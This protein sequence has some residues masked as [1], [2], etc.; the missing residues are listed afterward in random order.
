MG[1]ELVLAVDIGTSSTKALLFDEDLNQKA[2]CR[3]PNR[4][5][6]RAGGRSEQDPDDVFV[7]VLEAMAEALRATQAR[8][9]LA[10][11]VI[12]SQMYSVLALSAD[13]RPLTN[14]I[15]WL[16]HRAA[17]VA[18]NFRDH[19][20]ASQLSERTGC[21]I[22]PIF[23]FS[24]ILW[25][26]E[27]GQIPADA[28]FIS[29]KEY[30]LY[31]L[32][33]RLLADWAIGSSSGLMDIRTREWDPA[34]V[35][36]TRLEPSNLPVLTTPSTIITDWDPMVAEKVGVPVGTP[37]ILGSGDGPL[38]SVGVGALSPEILAINVGTSA[39]ARCVINMPA[40]DPRGRL[41][42]QAFDETHW[43][44]GGMTSSGGI[45]HEWFLEQFCSSIGPDGLPEVK[46]ADR[47]AAERLA[48]SVPP[49]SDGLMFIPYLSGEQSPGWQAS[50]RGSFI[51][52]TLK[53]T[54]GH[55]ARSVLEGI[56]R[57]LYRIGEAFKA[58]PEFRG[59]S[60]REIRVT[61]GLTASPLGLQIM[62][63]MFNLPVIVP[64][65][66]EGSARGAAILAWS[67]L[68]R[69]G[70]TKDY[71]RP[72]PVKARAEPNADAHFCYQQQLYEHNLDLIRDA[73]F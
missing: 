64:E 1:N 46:S 49:G 51:G 17:E 25:L 21:P 56:T 42:T 48:A 34:A 63:D 14:S 18:L 20:L 32:T 52:L 47:E 15:T 41:Y 8:D 3:R 4:I 12:S 53:H 39:A 67:T 29:I 54:R 37:I 16:D 71:S 5:L 28:R 38:A 72:L 6:D 60:F 27:S 62:A 70:T 40:G 30:V 13:G 7:G 58:V 23:P 33:G 9:R 55:L 69:S 31:R 45:V 10:A 26:K 2:S 43:V 68:R 44:M 57:S 65:L 59:V 36:I 19:P 73:R 11:L 66:A 35:S 22:H 50:I 61:G 24:K